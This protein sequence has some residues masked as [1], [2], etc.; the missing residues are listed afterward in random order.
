MATYKIPESRIDDIMTDAEYSIRDEAG[1][2]D[3]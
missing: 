2:S 1:D 3:E